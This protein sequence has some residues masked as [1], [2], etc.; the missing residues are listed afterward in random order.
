[1]ISIMC[2]SIIEELLIDFGL[3][4]LDMHSK[5]S[6]IRYRSRQKYAFKRPIRLYETSLL[7]SHPTVRHSLQTRGICVKKYG[8]STR[9]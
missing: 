3:S 1:M 8:L 2:V 4:D 5:F 7:C 9:I 6:Q